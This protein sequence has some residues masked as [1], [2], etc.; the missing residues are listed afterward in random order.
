[1]ISILN[2][3]DP[4]TPLYVSAHATI[5]EAMI[6]GGSIVSANH[7]KVLAL[8]S[9]DSP[10]IAKMQFWDDG[11]SICEDSIMMAAIIELSDTINVRDATI[12]ALQADALTS[13]SALALAF[14]ELEPMHLPGVTLRRPRIR[15]DRSLR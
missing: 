5:E 9:F 2:I 6:A 8:L 7:G 4:E 3:T 10:R 14:T 15:V 1:M 12:S 11:P 13:A